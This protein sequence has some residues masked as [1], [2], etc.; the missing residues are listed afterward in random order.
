[1]RPLVFVTRF[2]LSYFLKARVL[3][4][5]VAKPDH[6]PVYFAKHK[7]V[8]ITSTHKCRAVFSVKI[9]EQYWALFSEAMAADNRCAV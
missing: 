7:R 1:M 4:Q 3:L 8:I 5:K 9:S 6:R 2:E